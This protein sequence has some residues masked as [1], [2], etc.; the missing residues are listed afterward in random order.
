M[1][2]SLRLKHWKTHYDSV[3]EFSQGTNVLV[4]PMGSGKTSVVDA[5]SYALFANFPA[6]QAKQ[7]SLPDM[8]MRKPNEMKEAEIQLIFSSDNK[9]Y[10]IKR[11]VRKKKANE[12]YLFEGTKEGNKLVAGPKQTDVT[13]RIQELLGIDYNLFSRA[14]YCTQ[15]EID[16][17]LRLSP[18]ERKK[19]L[20][21]LFELSKYELARGNAVKAKNLLK[22][23]IEEKNSFL[24][25][26][27]EGREKI[28]LGREE[29]LLKE[30][31]VELE[32]INTQ[33]IEKKKELDNER[34]GLLE[35]EKNKKAFDKTQTQVIQLKTLLKEL[36][37]T[38]GRKEPSKPFEKINAELDEAKE[39]LSS[40]RLE[41]E[42]VI[43]ELESKKTEKE[44]GEKELEELNARKA[45]LE[46]KEKKL[47]SIVVEGIQAKEKMLER[48]QAET[49]R[50]ETRLE[51]VLHALESLKKADAS[52]PTCE[53]ELAEGQKRKLVKEKEADE[54]SLNEKISVSKK[55]LAVLGK[56]L[57]ELK[58]K[59]SD[60]NRLEIEVRELKQLNSLIEGKK[61]KLKGIKVEGIKEKL[62]ALK[63]D[64]GKAEERVNELKE[65]LRLSELIEKRKHAETEA[66]NA[67]K[68]LKE[69]AFNENEFVQKSN[70][71]ARE[72]EKINSLEGL[73]QKLVESINEKKHH[74]ESIKKDLAR[75]ESIKKEV[76]LLDGSVER[77]SLFA[78]ALEKTQVELRRHLIE[79]INLAMDDL[80]AKLYPYQDYLSAQIQVNEGD[81]DL[82][83]K[84]LNGTWV[85][86][87]GVLSGGERSAAAITIRIAI[88]LVLAKKLSWLILD[89]PTH[90]LDSNAIAM[91]SRMLKEH[92]PELVEQ[93]F[94]I[95]HD[96]EL[97][98]AASSNVYLLNRNKDLNEATKPELTVR[99]D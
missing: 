10:L 93:I 12:A 38:I 52:C 71:I 76:L 47:E 44:I 37:E 83:V 9:D 34:N 85:K 66:K 74:I 98:K 94:I 64:F 43:G 24:K 15:N 49:S 97:E 89:E 30:K 82:V 36:N 28:D 50:N 57:A 31:E 67:E 17:F 48:Q 27:E 46:E 11:T 62:T 68:A 88:S 58:E 20:D 14:I 72:E 21:D 61:K 16:Y 79:S 3:F 91:L 75:I 51:L 4:G 63:N 84:E 19:K 65:M 90:N 45:L 95:T 13:E 86:V 54:K 92:L 96:K 41:A 53:A 32:R 29:S 78:S 69:I 26:F 80:W 42:T 77:L 99:P 22:K 81:Y 59:E 6:L 5:I 40:I 39:S 35:L 87:E 33:S 60:K 1:I 73:R 8:I 55:A 7:A 2:K 23:I 25:Q 56:E 18:A 70:F